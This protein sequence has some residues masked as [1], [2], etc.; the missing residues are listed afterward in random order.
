AVTDPLTAPATRRAP[1][2]PARDDASAARQFRPW[3]RIAVICSATPPG[4]AAALGSGQPGY[5]EGVTGLCQR[6]GTSRN[7]R[8]PTPI[9]AERKNRLESEPCRAMHATRRSG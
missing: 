1:L 3:P 9:P 2:S 5:E 4:G 7:G 8:G 6:D